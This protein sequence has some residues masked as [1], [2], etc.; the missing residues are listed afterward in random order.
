MSSK[1]PEISMKE[2]LNQCD[3]ESPIHECLRV[4]RLRL[5]IFIDPLTVSFDILVSNVDRAPVGTLGICSPW[6][7]N[8][9]PTF[10]THGT[11][12]WASCCSRWRRRICNSGWVSDDRMSN[13][14]GV[15]SWCRG[16]HCWG[17]TSYI[18]CGYMSFPLDI[19]T[20]RSRFCD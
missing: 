1:S 3:G 8:A 17:Q 9:F 18:S 14:T 10:Y 11:C 12:T 7:M 13:S 19:K 6:T 20:R 15:V 2:P 4:K 5:L 16:H